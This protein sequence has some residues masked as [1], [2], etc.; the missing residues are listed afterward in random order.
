M[1]GGICWREVLEREE[2]GLTD[3][4]EKERNDN[5]KIIDW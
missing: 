3:D 1:K 2:I 4:V 5:S